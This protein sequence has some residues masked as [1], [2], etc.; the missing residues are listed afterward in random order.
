[1]FRTFCAARRAS[2]LFGAGTAMAGNPGDGRNDSR[3]RA[4][5]FQ[6]FLRN[7]HGDSAV[8]DLAIEC[9]KDGIAHELAIFGALPIAVK[10]DAHVAKRAA[11]V[12]TF[13]S[14]ADGLIHSVDFCAQ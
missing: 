1:M 2:G 13:P 5:E 3:A 9:P 4:S 11:A 12:G 6:R 7:V 8:W 14:P 10:V